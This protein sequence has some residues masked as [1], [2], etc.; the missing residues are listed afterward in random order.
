MKKL[1]FL[2]TLFMLLM[3]GCRPPIEEPQPAQPV[4]PVETFDFSLLYTDNDPFWGP[5]QDY[6]NGQFNKSDFKFSNGV[7]IFNA[8]LSAWG[9]VMFFADKGIDHD[10]RVDEM[11]YELD[12]QAKRIREQSDATKKRIKELSKYMAQSI[13]R[14]IDRITISKQLALAHN[15]IDR[16]NDLTYYINA[17]EEERNSFFDINE[18]YHS[19]LMAIN[20]RYPDMTQ[21]DPQ[22]RDYYK[23]VYQLLSE[24]A[25]SDYSA[26]VKAVYYPKFLASQNGMGMPAIYK[27]FCRGC[28]AWSNE[29]IQMQTYFNLSDLVAAIQGGQMTYV[30]LTACSYLNI[31][32]DPI[33]C[34]TWK[35]Q[36]MENYLQYYN[37]YKTNGVDSIAQ[38]KLD[39][40]PECLI[41]G[42]HFKADSTASLIPYSSHLSTLKKWD[43]L[44]LVY[45]A[46]PNQ[47]KQ[48]ELIPDSLV[49][50][51]MDF[52][53]LSN[54]SFAQ[55]LVNNGMKL[56]TGVDAATCVV[57]L[58]GKCEEQTD[59]TATPGHSVFCSAAF[60]PLY[61]EGKG[62]TYWLGTAQ[63]QNNK[64][65]WLTLDPNNWLC[66]KRIK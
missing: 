52:Y 31:G 3:V 21:N 26:V 10:K 22:L 16:L 30:F 56:P 47:V 58:D 20:A 5:Q 59:S 62:A 38:V 65:N 57:L 46:L 40:Y 50:K 35:Q 15:T 36:L 24:W 66:V 12:K 53:Q 13:Q 33:V 1:A 49:Q 6:F 34:N 29:A 4:Q 23:E 54:Q 17:A 48:S 43:V 42:A 60:T 44:S 7:S 32:P 11:N 28:C 63:Q 45:G 37:L 27:D 25:Q 9:Y 14:L 19:A 64:Y 51:V 39:P 2:L 55:I 18:K 8:F 41:Q 61:Y